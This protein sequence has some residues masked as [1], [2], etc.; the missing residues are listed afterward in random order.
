[1]IGPVTPTIHSGWAA[2]SEKRAAA[3]KVAI[4]T[5]TTP[6]SPVVSIRSRENA[7]AGSTLIGRLAAALRVA[8]YARRE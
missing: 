8:R 2:K 6:Y 3:T 7:I 1:M 5:S 4:K